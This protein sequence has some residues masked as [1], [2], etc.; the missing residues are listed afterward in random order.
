MED[1]LL[2]QAIESVR[3]GFYDDARRS[4]LQLVRQDPNNA[5]AWLWL[6]QALDDPKRQLDCLRQ[7]LRID[8]NNQDALWGMNALQ[9]GRPLPELESGSVVVADEEPEPEPE[10]FT[11][12]Q[13]FGWGALFDEEPAGAAPVVAPPPIAVPSSV[14]EVAPPLTFVVEEEMLPVE[15][16]PSVVEPA[17]A[18]ESFLQRARRMRSQGFSTPVAPAPPEVSPAAAPQPAFVPPFLDSVAEVAVEAP[19]PAPVRKFRLF[20]RRVLFSILG[21]LELPI[22][23]AL[24]VLLLRGRSV[25][26]PGIPAA[27]PQA[28]RPALKVCRDLNLGEFTLVE[29]LGG[30]L[31]TDTIFTGTQVVITETLVVP[32]E[33]RLLI[34]PGATLVFSSGATIEVYG[35][36]YA[37]GNE[38]APVAFTAWDK[39]PGGWEGI[40]LYN[41]LEASVFSHAR[42]DYAG[43]RALYLFNS[44]PALSD[45]TIAN[46]ALFAISF[47]GGVLPDMS[48]NVNISDN[49]V[50]G[51]EVRPGTL[52]LSNAVWPN[53][54]VVYVVSGRL[55]VGEGMTLDIQPGVTV[56]FWQMPGGQLP[57]IWVRG[58]LK[59]DSVQFTSIFDSRPEVGG[60]TYR[61]A[62]DPQPGDWGSLTFYESSEK[63]YL[64][65]VSIYYGGHA[66]AA[67]FMKA[68]SP[69]L[70]Q[71]TISDSAGY[72]LSSDVDSFPVVTTVTL[73]GNR[74]GDAMEI[75]GGMTITG[76]EER[77]WD[78]LGG[79]TPI[80]RVVHDTIT[81]GSQARLTIRPGVVVKFTETG[82]LV[83]RGAL[84]AVGGGNPE[85]IIFTSVHDDD[86]GGDI[87]GV[88]TPQDSRAW[89]GISLEGVDATTE[90][91]YVIVRY[92]PLT[93][94]DAAPKL[95]DVQIYATSGAGLRMTPGSSPTLSGIQ[96]GGNG[97]KGIV[98][99][100]GTIT[101]DHTWTRF[102]EGATQLM[103]VLEG[104]VTVE[105]DAVL[106]IDIGTVIK[107]GAAGKLTILGHLNAIGR[108]NQEIIL[109]SLNDDIL[110]DTNNRL[111]NPGP[112]DW[113]G[114]EVGP[115]ANVHL[116]YVGIYH[117]QV[118][119]TVRGATMPTIDEGRVHIARGKQP[120]S[121]TARMQI[122]PAFLFEDNEVAVTRCPTP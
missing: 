1:P 35:A 63:S 81:V 64:R 67:V 121:C 32:G 117:A 44:A 62:I 113:L 13:T 90:M 59:A 39:T 101:T 9:A 47:D 85:E 21:L 29:T 68:S 88:T 91:E 109:T 73:T 114:V 120:L 57:G 10:L 98:V 17:A 36:L 106:K 118:G 28:L 119:L 55:L 97:I 16:P 115:E 54:N 34:Y 4:L 96:F 42:I 69:E 18:P 43:E 19:A 26:L 72:P 27:A 37:C 5:L 84:S 41:P 51:I 111:L 92:A 48:Q 77:T 30:T 79:D 104:E 24:G 102:G 86:Y 56:K 31:T 107:A 14:E 65:N 116:A 49:P 94:E 2:Y 53:M 82:K 66:T 12:E 61:E 76:E 105:P 80:A 7:V 75:Y 52:M 78:K 122:S 71:V 83:V 11:P 46:S 60:V 22:V 103:R 100:T 3:L 25:S 50:N 38:A 58:L 6:A 93:L 89:G 20:D 33:R 45:V 108:S 95:S 110:G 23:I 74:S 40:R 87:D 8:P 70:T 112:S 99:M 15:E